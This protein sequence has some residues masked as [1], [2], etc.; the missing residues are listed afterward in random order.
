MVYFREVFCLYI[1]DGACVLANN[2]QF[3]VMMMTAAFG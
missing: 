3:E 2:L 1:L